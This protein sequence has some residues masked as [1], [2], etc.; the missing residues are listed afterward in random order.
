MGDPNFPQNIIRYLFDNIY[1]TFQQ[2]VFK[3]IYG[4]PMGC[5]CCVE[6]ANILCFSYEYVDASQMRCAHATGAKLRRRAYNPPIH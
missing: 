6:I 4:I 5:N 1:S 2:Q 3:Q